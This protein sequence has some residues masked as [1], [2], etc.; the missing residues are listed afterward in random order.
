M[1]KPHCCKQPQLVS[2]DNLT[3]LRIRGTRF[4]LENDFKNFDSQ[5]NMA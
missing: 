4:L 3:I 1:L 2:L 5:K